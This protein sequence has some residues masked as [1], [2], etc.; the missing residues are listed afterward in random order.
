MANCVG[1]CD[2]FEAAG[3]SAV[4]NARGECIARLP[5]AGEGALLLDT[6]TGEALSIGA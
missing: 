6:A 4:W 3:R 1:P 2:G 5:A